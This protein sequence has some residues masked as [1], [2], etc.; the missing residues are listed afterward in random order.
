MKA[1]LDSQREYERKIRQLEQK[2]E[3]TAEKKRCIAKTNKYLKRRVRELSASRDTWKSKNAAKALKVKGLKKRIKNEGKAK[4]HHYSLLAISLCV[5]LRAQAGCSYRGICKILLILQGSFDL[6]L[7]RLPCAN[8]V[9][10][11]VSKMG[12]YY[13]EHAQESLPSKEVCL[14]LDESIKQGNERVLLLLITPWEKEKQ[15]ALG[16]NDVR[17]CYLGGKSSWTG[18]KI[19][20][21]VEK[22]AREK[23]IE[24]KGALSDEDTKLLKACRLLGLPHLPDINHAVASCLRKTF[25]KNEVYK[26]LVKQITAYQFKAVNQDLSYLRPPKQRVKARFMN[27]KGFVGW[28]LVMLEKFTELN[29]KEAA[30]FEELPVYE[31]MLKALGRCIG[32]G[33]KIAQLLKTKGLS[34]QTLKEAEGCIGWPSAPFKFKPVD[35]SKLS[36]A[37]S[38][39][40]TEA[41]LY[42]FFEHMRCYIARYKA[43]LSTRC[44][45]FNASSDIIESMF[46]KHKSISG[47]NTLTGVTQLDLELPLCNMGHED[48]YP[49]SKLALESVFMADLE[50]WRKIHS[51]D[52]QA[53]KRREFF[54]NG[55]KV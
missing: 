45:V 18:E 9:E 52:N 47:T 37:L 55:G 24:I 35:A 16:Y 14:I 50:A 3:R 27:Q 40:H 8:T 13:M 23:G 29:E 6:G 15:A 39:G 10:N 11:W 44:G 32:T 49:L 48:I 51:S 19:K 4:R 17:V 38:F 34:S 31:P 5:K 1:S 12:Y 53:R 21:E 42:Q 43:F 41:L 25:E 46:G 26:S 33:E 7:R 20:E 22:I 30:F 2:L 36:A 54:K 28:G